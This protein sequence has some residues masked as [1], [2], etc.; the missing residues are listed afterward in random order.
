MEAIP[1]G[2]HMENVVLHAEE[3][4]NHAQGHATILHR[5]M[6]EKT[7]KSLEQQLN[8]DHAILTLAQV[9]LVKSKLMLH[10]KVVVFIDKERQIDT[11][12]T[13]NGY[14]DLRLQKCTLQ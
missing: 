5:L 7:A 10:S 8:Q 9:C 1:N 6:V 12:I 11:N 13:L 3:A 14:R 2:Q 4:R